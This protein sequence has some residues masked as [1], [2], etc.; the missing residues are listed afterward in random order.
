MSIRVPIDLNNI[1]T[2][3]G[4]PTEG[5][6]TLEADTGL[7]GKRGDVFELMD[8]NEREPA[9][10]IVPEQRVSQIVVAVAPLRRDVGEASPYALIKRLDS[11]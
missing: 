7:S 8:T 2:T 1:E 3:S 4:S 9:K 11:V 5:T 10:L 6:R